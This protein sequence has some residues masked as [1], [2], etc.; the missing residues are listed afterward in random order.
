MT[1]APENNIAPPPAPRK[2]RSASEIYDSLVSNIQKKYNNQLTDKEAHEAA[3]N[4]LGFCQKVI[5]IR[6]REIK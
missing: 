1:E 3:R 2:H 4:L 5:E 6:S